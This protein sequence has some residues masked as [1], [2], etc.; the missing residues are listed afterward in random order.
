MEHPSGSLVMHTNSGSLGDDMDRESLADSSHPRR[1][2]RKLNADIVVKVAMSLYK[3]QQNI[4]L[5][6]FQRIE[7]SLYSYLFIRF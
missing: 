6:D 3:V 7:V 4:Y 5:L 1:R 2:H